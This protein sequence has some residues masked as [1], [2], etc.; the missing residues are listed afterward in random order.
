MF[1]GGGRRGTLQLRCFLLTFLAYACT[2]MLRTPIKVIRLD[3]ITDLKIPMQHTGWM[4]TALL[5][6]LG[7]IQ[8]ISSGWKTQYSPRHLLA[9][10]L[11]GS[12]ISMILF[13]VFHKYGILLL[14][15]FLN[16]AMQAVVFPQC[17]AALALWYNDPSRRTT[18]FG[19]W[20]MSAS[21]GGL[22]GTALATTIQKKYA[23]HSTFVI[24]SL[25]AGLACIIIFKFL[26]MPTA[27][28]A[29]DVQDS[30]SESESERGGD[31][32]SSTRELLISGD[33]YRSSEAMLSQQEERMLETSSVQTIGSIEATS[34]LTLLE[35]WRLPMVKEVAATYFCVNV[36]RYAVT[37]WLP[38]FFQAK[39]GYSQETSNWLS[40]AFDVG[41]FLGTPGLALL[42]DNL[43]GGRKMFATQ[44]ALIISSTSLALFYITSG[45]GRVLNFF[46][47]ILAGF[48]SG[49]TDMVL[50]GSLAVDLGGGKRNCISGVAGII[51]GCGILGAVLQGGLVAFTYYVGGQTGTAFLMSVLAILPI[52]VISRAAK[53]DRRA[54]TSVLGSRGL[55]AR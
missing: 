33:T 12:A 18:V 21:V 53:L 43:L 15:L 28:T 1:R 54:K 37:M 4:D 41:A 7:V 46:F 49:G 39:V 52:F 14:C 8:I 51:N 45:W 13:G 50:T 55:R 16:G 29:V 25:V 47:L 9:Y 30:Q 23:W 24:P 42:S 40:M 36:L 6:P 26:R 3:V 17:I 44:M 48:A 22:L 38:I 20:G 19:V 27:T 2:F 5:L 35:M 32:G 34:K 10:A 31:G 11:F